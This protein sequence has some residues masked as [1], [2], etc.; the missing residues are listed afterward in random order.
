MQNANTN[1]ER[2]RSRL[3]IGE[4]AIDYLRPLVCLR[5]RELESQESSAKTK[6][7]TIFEEISE[8]RFAARIANFEFRISNF[9]SLKFGEFVRNFALL[10]LDS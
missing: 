9:G 1:L 8:L 6:T 5:A 10:R 7:K 4:Q 3:D 2:R